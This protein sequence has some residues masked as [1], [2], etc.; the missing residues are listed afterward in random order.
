MENSTY[1]SHSLL[2]ALLIGFHSQIGHEIRPNILHILSLR[3]GW[4]YALLA[5][6]SKALN[7]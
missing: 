5:F 1:I 4:I 7:T 2:A 6:S 3:I